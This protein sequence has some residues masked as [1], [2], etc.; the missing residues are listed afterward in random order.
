MPFA[1]TQEFANIGVL[2][3]SPQ[4]GFIGYKLAPIR[5]K[6]V[7]D[8]FDD[9]DGKLYSQVMKNLE[10]EMC[11]VVN[12]AKNIKGNE[13]VAFIKE[14]TRLREGLIRFSIKLNIFLYKYA[15]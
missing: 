3:F 15:S 8:F 10:A 13:L 4:S 12:K 1:E 11:Y 5:F 9:L 7:T 2:A 6:R 14:L